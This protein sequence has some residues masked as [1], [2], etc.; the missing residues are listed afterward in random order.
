MENASGKDTGWSDPNYDE[1]W[2]NTVADYYNNVDFRGFGYKASAQIPSLYGAFRRCYNLTT[3]NFKA[4]TNLTKIGEG[5]FDECNKLEYMVGTDTYTYKRYNGKNN[6]VIQYASVD[7]DI[8]A[9][10]LDLSECSKLRSINRN[11]FTNCNKIKYLHLPDNRDGASQSTLYIGNDLENPAYLNARGGIIS[12]NKGIKVL[13]KETVYYAEID[14]GKSNS[15]STHYGNKLEYFGGN[16]GN[17]N[18]LYYYVGSAS[19]IPSTDTSSLNY[20]TINGNDEYVLFDTTNG[21]QPAV[22]ARNYFA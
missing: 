13:I 4:M 14:Y 8:S 19:D 15:A 16:S 2:D 9:G 5:A 17:N 21:R 18:K 1:V 11:A 12:G 6:G 10:V 3:M 7:T 20:W 22:D